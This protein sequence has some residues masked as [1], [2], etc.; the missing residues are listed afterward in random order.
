MNKNPIQMIMQMMA[1]GTIPKWL[2]GN[3]AKVLFVGSIPTRT[4]SNVDIY[5]IM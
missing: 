4:S 1:T 3:S 2:R 5:E